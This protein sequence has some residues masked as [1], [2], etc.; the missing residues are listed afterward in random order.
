MVQALLLE[1][2]D[3]ITHTVSQH[4][5]QW[6]RVLADYNCQLSLHDYV[7]HCYGHGYTHQARILIDWF[8]LKANPMI[9]AGIK[10]FYAKD[11]LRQTTPALTPEALAL[12][13][14]Y[15]QQNCPIGII[16]N[17]DGSLITTILAMH[18]LEDCIDVVVCDHHSLRSKP[19]PDMYRTALNTLRVSAHQCLAIETTACGIMAARSAGIYCVALQHSTTPIST[20]QMADDCIAS[21]HELYDSNKSTTTRRYHKQSNHQQSTPSKKITPPKSDFYLSKNVGAST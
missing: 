9:L 7:I 20:L 12:L 19:S 1:F 8:Q 11:W 15:R 17:S 4:H 6:N 21:L 14:C 16:S 10:L 3:V 18:G 5:Q 2:D 13:N